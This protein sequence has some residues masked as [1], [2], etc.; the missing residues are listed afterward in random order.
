[1]IQKFKDYQVNEGIF[2]DEPEPIKGDMDF[3]YLK[4][5]VSKLKEELERIKKEL[6]EIKSLNRRNMEN[7]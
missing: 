6:H 5:E 7:Y 1:M 4:S 2:Q 3:E